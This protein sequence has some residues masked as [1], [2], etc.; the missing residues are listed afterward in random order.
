[1]Q[2]KKIVM[3]A[4]HAGCSL[5]RALKTYLT[6]QGYT[7]SDYGTNDE[8]VPVD[9]P[10]KA[11]LLAK[12]IYTGEADIGLLVCGSGIGMSIAVNR[13]DF[14]RGALVCTPEMA[15]LARRHNNANVLVLGGRLTDIETAKACV[16]AFLTTPFD[17]G[18][19]EARV[20]ALER[21]PHDFE[22]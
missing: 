17:G 7:V 11:F 5:K 19:H 6:E 9:Y 2:G 16:D 13:Y 4:D 3:A 18:R 1:M 22:N 8:T 20:A 21:M 10:E 14:I 15:T 12:G